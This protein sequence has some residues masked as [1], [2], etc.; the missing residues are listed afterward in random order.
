MD[1]LSYICLPQFDRVLMKASELIELQRAMAEEDEDALREARYF[2]LIAS[3]PEASKCTYDEA[4]VNQ[5]VFSCITCSTF[6]RD[7]AQAH[8]VA[9]LR[10]LRSRLRQWHLTGTAPT[11]AGDVAAADEASRLGLGAESDDDVLSQIAAAQVRGWRGQ[12]LGLCFGCAHRCHKDH[13]LEPVGQRA[14]FRCDC[15]L[16]PPAQADFLAPGARD[17]AAA[18]A[19]T[20]AGDRGGRGEGVAEEKGAIL[21]E[22]EEPVCLLPG[23]RSKSAE[24]NPLNSYNANFEGVYCRCNSGGDDGDVTMGDVTMRQCVRCEDYFHDPCVRLAPPPVALVRLP[25]PLQEPLDAVAAL[26]RAG[27][28]ASDVAAASAAAADAVSAYGERFVEDYGNAMGPAFV[29]AECV[30]RDPDFARYSLR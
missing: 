15:G 4:Y 2:R 22:H 29:C 30:Q 27:A 12:Y 21:F 1:Q 14:H 5:T 16:D 24:G 6:R 10:A 26:V 17:P 3:F 8:A 28:P 11:A 7:K 9:D 23:G 13:I 25:H 20:D 19:A 18:A